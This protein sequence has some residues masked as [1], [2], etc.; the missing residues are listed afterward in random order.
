MPN[1]ER[2]LR[3]AR[4]LGKAINTLYVVSPKLAGKMAFQVFSTPRRIPLWPA[5]LAFF[6]KSIQHKVP[7][8]RY[9]LCVYEW[10]PPQQPLSLKTILLLHGWD[11]SSARWRKLV[12]AL[13]KAGYRVLAMDAPAS[14]QS[15]GKRLNLGLFSKA[16]LAVEERFG[17][18]Y[19]RIG[20]S[21]GGAAAVMTTAL[22]AGKAP[23]KIV[24]MGVFA[25]S[26]RVI[27]G[28]G[29]MMH[30]EQPVLDAVDVEVKRI[31]GRSLTE[32]SVATQVATL[33]H[34]RGF[35]IH[36]QDDAIAPV[37]EGRLV[38]EAWKAQYLETVCY[39]HSLQHKRVNEAI[40]D[41]LS[42]E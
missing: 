39:G 11:S 27:A 15:G 20:H 24:L 22:Y 32:F 30:L 13:L 5:D 6:S 37:A 4:R 29:Q 12:N 35:V 19:A 31:T 23:E 16:V 10:L 41:F 14:G 25:E 21:L 18:P 26:T 34:V 3:W 36:D 9:E 40:L 1:S 42:T 28:F 38:A 17:L 2:F 8:R 7:F 33:T